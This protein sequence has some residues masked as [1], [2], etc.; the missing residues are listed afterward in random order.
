MPRLQTVTL[1][2][3]DVTDLI[4]ISPF[5]EGEAIQTLSDVGW[6][7]N[8][9]IVSKVGGVTVASKAVTTKTVDDLYYSVSWGSPDTEILDADQYLWVIEIQNL[10]IIPIWR[11]EYNIS[12]VVTQQSLLRSDLTEVCYTVSSVTDA[13]VTVPEVVIPAGIVSVNLKDVY[14]DII[15]TTGFVESST[16]SP[17]TFITLLEEVKKPLD[18][19]SICVRH[20]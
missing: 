1:K 16:T 5:E 3:G 12:L 14:G 11:K 2:Q 18:V 4:N 20:T 10:G 15:Q 13:I 6:T 19:A 17:D 9:S 8:T 7:C